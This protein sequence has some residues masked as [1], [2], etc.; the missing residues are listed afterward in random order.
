MGKPAVAVLAAGLGSRFGGDKLEAIC[1]GKPLGRWAIEAVEAADLGPGFIVFGAECPSYAEGWAHLVNG[2]PEEGLSS[3]LTG[4]AHF[5]LMDGA[6]TLLVLL[7]DMP[8]VSP[9]YL[10]ELAACPAPAATRYPE[11]HAGVPALLDREMI[12]LA[13]GLTGDRGAGAL[14]KG[15]RLLDPPA[16]ML[17]DVDTPADLAEAERQLAR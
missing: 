7:A 15:A 3:S 8:L 16:E 13:A 5:A 2:A 4:A 1:A 14:L 12:E 17:F 9:D 10:R 11:G 6:D